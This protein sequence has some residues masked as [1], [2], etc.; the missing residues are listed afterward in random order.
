MLGS[1]RGHA[2]SD[3][4]ALPACVDRLKLIH[5]SYDNW[6]FR[7]DDRPKNFDSLREALPAAIATHVSEGTMENLRR[8]TDIGPALSTP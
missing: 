5:P 1:A 8:S 2:G 4:G 7:L 6:I 3:R